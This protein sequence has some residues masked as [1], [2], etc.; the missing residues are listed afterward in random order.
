MAKLT[1]EDLKKLRDS[2]KKSTALREGETSVKVTVHM[3]TC[4]IAAGA[5][6]VMDALLQEVTEAKRSDI[7]VIT[8]G[9][10][11]MCSSEP[12]VTVEISGNEPVIYQH[13]DRNRMRQ[14]FKRHVLLGEVQ[15]DFALARVK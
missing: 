9:C 10:M 13:M 1:I 8:S 11:G 3:G 2:A 14:V 12:N 7:R 15:T 4:G 6:E 5:R